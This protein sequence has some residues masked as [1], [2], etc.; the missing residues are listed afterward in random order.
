MTVWYTMATRTAMMLIFCQLLKLSSSSS[1]TG[2]RKDSEITKLYV[3]AEGADNCPHWIEKQWKCEPLSYY[4][5]RVDQFFVSNTCMEFLEGVHVME[6]NR[7]VRMVDISNFSLIG[8]R[9]RITPRDTTDGTPVPSSLITCS[10]SMR[11]GF[12]FVN[13]F[14][15]QIENLAIAKCGMRISKGIK[16]LAAI[17]FDTVINVQMRNVRIFNS[18]GFGVHADRVLGNSTISNS[19]FIRNIGIK[20]FYGGN[21]RFWYRDCPSDVNTWLL[22]ENSWFMHGYDVYKTDRF[23]PYASGLTLLIDC[24]FV[25]VTISNITA[26]HNVADNGGN[27]AIRLN[28][29]SY[30]PGIGSILLQNSNIVGGVGHRGG[31]LRVW[32]RIYGARDISCRNLSQNY[33]TLHVVNTNFTDNHAKSAGGALYISHY[34]EERIDCVLR[35]IEFVRCNFLRNSVPAYG[36]GAVM[37]IIKHTIPTVLPHVSPQFQVSFSKSHFVNNWIILDEKML[38]HGGILDIFSV[39]KILFESCTFTDNNSTALS[40]VDSNVLLSG[41]SLFRNNSGVNGGAVK[42]CDSSYMYIEN[43][44]SVTFNGNCAANAGGAIF[45]QQRCLETAP[46][47]FFQTLMHDFTKLSEFG[48]SI[49]MSLVFVNNTAGSAG[50]AIYGGSIDECYT[51]QHYID[52]RRASYYLSDQVFDKI[53]NTSAED[54]DRDISSNPSGVCLCDSKTRKPLCGKQHKS[55]SLD[56]KYPGEVFQIM[57]VTVGQRSGFSPAVV[58][59]IVI[60][61]EGN[62]SKLL[63]QLVT[64]PLKECAWLKYSVHTDRSIMTFN[65]TVKQTN[66]EAYGF[67]YRY[68]Y[69]QIAVPLKPCL[70]GFRLSR[71][72]EGMLSCQCH[73]ALKSNGINC[74]L[75]AGYLTRSSTKWVGFDWSK[76]KSYEEFQRSCQNMSGNDTSCRNVI[77]STKC[78]YDYC[79]HSPVNI[80]ASSIDKQCNF[81]RGGVLC[82]A[83]KDG[84]SSA[85]GESKCKRCINNNNIIPLIIFFIFAGIFLVFILILLNLTVTEGTLNGLIFYMNMMQVNNP[86]YFPASGISY[87]I[88]I[89]MAI[90]AW[91]NLDLGIHVCFYSGM[92]AYTKAWLQF[93]FPVYIWLIVVFIIVLSR[94]FLLVQRLVGKNAVK[95]L[96]TLFLLS[97][98]KLSRAIISVLSY[99]CLEYPSG[100]EVLVWIPDGNVEFLG[101]K[102][103]PLFIVGVTFM[104]LLLFYTFLVMF[105]MCLQ[106]VPI[107]GPF[108]LVYRLKPFFDAYTGPYKTRYRFWTG[109]LLLTRCVLFTLFALNVLSE[110]RLKLMLTIL[111]CFLLLSLMASF[112]GVY[113]RLY[114]NLLEVLAFLNLGVVS[115]LTCFLSGAKTTVFVSA[116]SVIFACITFVVVIFFHGYR[117]IRNSKVLRKFLSSISRS[118]SSEDLVS[119]S[120]HVDVERPQS[121]LT[122]SEVALT[123]T[124]E[125][126][127]EELLQNMNS[128]VANQNVPKVA[129]FTQFR[130]PLIE[131]DSES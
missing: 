129:K 59:G 105:H 130:E 18:T 125:A 23:Y 25:H 70:W 24:P 95:I 46:S 117:Q 102:H 100:K 35:R 82:G 85:F 67:Y 111:T 62:Q 11:S 126:E 121:L 61:M 83:C 56:P 3:R 64:D 97:A 30:Q 6:I 107:G 2:D 124:G 40:L 118:P 27:L 33:V 76:F 45:A 44:T 69:P 26:M 51:F 29:T 71:D 108:K 55:I 54:P 41:R 39:D 120:L 36:N 113:R 14:N 17:A 53:F 58:N 32:S 37:E 19:A 4:I 99:V 109:L 112:Y 80:T 101:G 90:V 75:T 74:N 119:S 9:S 72:S 7:A 48:K 91:F 10:G 34:E 89:L 68:H 131:S 8:N 47:C 110:F 49:N 103:I 86:I 65:L 57:A 78:P 128:V 5:Q 127:A 73:Q 50:N 104:I 123:P 43:R 92:D 77:V 28:F 116:I 81:D 31:G 106:R 16:V 94:K 60:G 12:Y 63:K 22:V 114:L 42:I 38:V 93:V 87:G 52:H 96:A 20:K 21:M 98:A 84:R 115:T 15:I 122:Q 13:S 88:R 1:N 79:D 66:P